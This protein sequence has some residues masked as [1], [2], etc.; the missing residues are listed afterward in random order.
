MNYVVIYALGNELPKFS[1]NCFDL[2]LSLDI[3]CIEIWQKLLFG[4]KRLMLGLTLKK[5][6]HASARPNT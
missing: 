3:I 2:L 5:T 4:Y 6:I 1:W